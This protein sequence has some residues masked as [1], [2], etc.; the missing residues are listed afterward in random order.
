MGWAEKLPSGRYRGV[1]RDENGN[2][3]SAGIYTNKDVA[4]RKATAKEDRERENPSHPVP[5]TTWMEW[6]P[7][8]ALL[9]TAEEGTQKIDNHRIDKHLAPKWNPWLLTEIH[10][11]DVQEWVVEL[12]KT[13]APTSVEKCYR[14]LSSSMKA[15]RKAKLITETPCVDIDLPKP[16]PSPERHLEDEEVAALRDP[17]EPFDQ[18]IL[19]VLLGTGMRMGEAQGL[20]REHIDIKRKTI[21]IEWAWDKA[22][23]R[24]KAPKDHERRVIPIGESLTKILAATIKKNGL[25]EPAP[26]RYVD[27][28]RTVRSGLL[29]A[30]TDNRPFDQDNFR[31][32]FQAA[33]RVAWVGEGDDRRRLGKVRPNDLRH[34]YASRLVRAKVPLD[35]VQVLLGHASVRTTQRYARFGDSQWADVR[36][37][38]G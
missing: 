26:V 17:L 19:D 8:W 4:R 16:G 1:Y 22:T 5:A 15:A 24:M 29:L 23:K 7:R 12:S 32:R 2:K 38:L 37:T 27:D 28:G 25:G 36:R 20:H 35:Q 33:A 6:R 18:L 13:L 31:D 14:L 21:S 9:R 11:P 34:T 10:Q 30:H 3:R